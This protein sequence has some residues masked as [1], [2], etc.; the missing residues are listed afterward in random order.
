MPHYTYAL[1]DQPEFQNEVGP[2]KP[3]PT[4]HL[5]LTS[6][7]QVFTPVQHSFTNNLR[8]P[9]SQNNEDIRRYTYGLVNE[10]FGKKTTPFQSDVVIT[11]RSSTESQKS[12]IPKFTFALK[13]ET[14]SP[15]PSSEESNTWRWHQLSKYENELKAMEDQT[16]KLML[17]ESINVEQTKPSE[18]TTNN[19]NENENEKVK[20]KSLPKTTKNVPL[21]FS[22]SPKDETNGAATKTL[23]KSLPKTTTKLLTTTTTILPRHVTDEERWNTKIPVKSLTNTIVKT[24]PPISD[25]Y[26]HKWYQENYPLDFQRYGAPIYG[27]HV[28]PHQTQYSNE[29]KIEEKISEISDDLHRLENELKKEGAANE[30]SRNEKSILGQRLDFKA[31]RM[32]TNIDVTLTTQPTPLSL[33]SFEPNGPSMSTTTNYP[34]YTFKILNGPNNLE[35]NVAE[36]QKQHSDKGSLRRYSYNILPSTTP[37]PESEEE[38]PTERHPEKLTQRYK[39][40][41]VNQ[42]TPRPNIDST[43]KRYTYGLVTE[44]SK[45]ETRSDMDDQHDNLKTESIN[46]YTYRLLPPTEASF[47]VKHPVSEVKHDADKLN[48]LYDPNDGLYHPEQAPSLAEVF[49][50]TFEENFGSKLVV[51]SSNKVSRVKIGSRSRGTTTKYPN[52]N[53]IESK[54]TVETVSEI[55]NSFMSDGLTNAKG[56]EVTVKPDEEWSFIDNFQ[57][58]DLGHGKNE[59]SMKDQNKMDKN[60]QNTTD[61]PIVEYE[62]QELQRLKL[63]ELENQNPSVYQQV[64]YRD[65]LKPL[66]NTPAPRDFNTPK[67][68]SL[69]G[70]LNQTPIWP[71]AIRTLAPRIDDFG[72]PPT[73]QHVRLPGIRPDSKNFQPPF[74]VTQPVWPYG[75]DPHPHHHHD[76]AENKSDKE[77]HSQKHFFESTLKTSFSFE[78]LSIEKVKE[79]INQNAIFLSPAERENNLRPQPR[80]P[81]PSKRPAFSVDQSTRFPHHFSVVTPNSYIDFKVKPNTPPAFPSQSPITDVLPTN[82][83]TT[84]QEPYQTTFATTRVVTPKTFDT[85]QNDNFVGSTLNDNVE[86]FGDTTRTDNFETF[87]ETTRIDNFG[88]FGETTR[89]DNFENFGD[90]TRIDNFGKFGDTT[91]NDDFD[92]TSFNSERLDARPT[93]PLDAQRPTDDFLSTIPNHFQ[94]GTDERLSQM[95]ED[96]QTTYFGKMVFPTAEMEATTTE[97]MFEKEMIS[98]DILRAPI[99][100]TTMTPVNDFTTSTAT[101]TTTTTAT[102]TTTTDYPTVEYTVQT[103]APATLPAYNPFLFKD[104]IENSKN[105]NSKNVNSKLDSLSSPLPPPTVL[106]YTVTAP[107][108]LTNQNQPHPTQPMKLK[109]ER[110][111]PNNPIVSGTLPRVSP[112]VSKRPPKRPNMKNLLPSFSFGKFSTSSETKYP[113]IPASTR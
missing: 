77:K 110:R 61:R 58:F 69:S 88:N 52:V 72:P 14:T 24:L 5:L 4:S 46:K 50:T 68:N 37:M 3:V 105:V 36:S 59:S 9:Q 101:K 23:V 29:K 28:L 70:K 6:P 64:N 38:I 47:Q 55:T 25:A 86:N 32:S 91:R 20:V 49:P 104:E 17:E 111:R 100:A 99:E 108:F 113:N 51:D 11:Q 73:P 44:P 109:N 83:I 39:Y 43:P 66:L 26:I 87:R 19:E 27:Y 22:P 65:E 45:L 35:M 54:P 74:Q 56:K 89:I 102:K 48:T 85:T 71:T 62:G 21:P 90:T 80:R 8:N 2:Q 106:P 96:D 15:I 79:T 60:Y 13:P 16:E 1:K 42:T 78:P 10:D 112:K 76:S 95:F 57:Q 30:M 34:K 103:P 33:G 31:D 67:H 75:N 18:E 98:T 84:A 94:F 92:S 7:V 107:F 12:K 53:L 41:I 97:P 93:M 81:E 40:R 63:H 82:D